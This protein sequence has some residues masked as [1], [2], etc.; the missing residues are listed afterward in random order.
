VL[1]Q[2]SL[3]AEERGQLSEA[4]SWAVR[5]VALFTEVPHPMTGS[6]PR[7]LARLTGILGMPALAETWRE[8][9][10]DELPSA[11]RDYV[12]EQL[13]EGDESPRLR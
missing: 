12:E 1:T 13:R 8:A 9:T 3:L 4:L 7:D 11:V 10:G 5:C 2:R 6:G